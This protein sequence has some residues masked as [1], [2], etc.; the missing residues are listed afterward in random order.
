MRESGVKVPNFQPLIDPAKVPILT[1]EYAPV[2]I[3]SGH[4]MLHK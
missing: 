2:D 3:W 1:D 4:I